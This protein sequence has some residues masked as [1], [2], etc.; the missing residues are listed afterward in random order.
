MARTWYERI[1]VIYTKTVFKD[2]K[3]ERVVVNYS[4]NVSAEGRKFEGTKQKK[5]S[6]KQKEKQGEKI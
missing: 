2:F 1:F 5:N 6:R 4:E 3:G